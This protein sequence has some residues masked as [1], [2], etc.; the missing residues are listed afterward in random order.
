MTRLLP[1]GFWF[2]DF[3]LFFFQYAYMVLLKFEFHLLWDGY[4]S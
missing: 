2:P 4:R 1:L 3:S